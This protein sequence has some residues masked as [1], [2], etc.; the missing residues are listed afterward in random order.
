MRIAKIC[1][2]ITSAII[3]FLRCRPWSAISDV[4]YG[5]LRSNLGP[6]SMTAA[7][8]NFIDISTNSLLLS[9]DRVL[10]FCSYFQPKMSSWILFHLQSPGHAIKRG[11]SS[12][13]SWQFAKGQQEQQT[14]TKGLYS[15]ESLSYKYSNLHAKNHGRSKFG[16]RFRDT[17]P[18]PDTRTAYPIIHAC[19][20]DI[21]CQTASLYRGM[22]EFIAEPHTR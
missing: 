4:T 22:P 2:D 5:V 14:R 17:N 18:A 12:R 19:S 3:I 7:D 8:S 10:L 11:I 1:A 20:N 16:G 21:V 6:D 13:Q 15:N 9:R